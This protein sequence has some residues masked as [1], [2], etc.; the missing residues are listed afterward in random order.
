MIAFILSSAALWLA[1]FAWIL[2]DPTWA[3]RE[4]DSIL[5]FGVTVAVIPPLCTWIVVELVQWRASRRLLNPAVRARW[6]R[7]GLGALSA[8]LAI[9]T[10]AI[11]PPLWSRFLPA[12]PIPDALVTGLAS[13]VW[14]LSVLMFLARHVPGGCLHCGYD[15]RGSAGSLCPECGKARI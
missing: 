2:F 13:A 3:P 4:R 8:A 6:S 9:I 14:T 7:V 10:T 5:K 15:L 1:T 12:N 11:V